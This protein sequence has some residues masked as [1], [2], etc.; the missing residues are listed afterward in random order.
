MPS[1]S[2]TVLRNISQVVD[3]LECTVYIS[4]CFRYFMEES[5]I[6][7]WIPFVQ[8]KGKVNGKKLKCYKGKPL[9]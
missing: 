8:F 5:F 1:F 6:L 2:Q 3:A 9:E 7:Y 4:C